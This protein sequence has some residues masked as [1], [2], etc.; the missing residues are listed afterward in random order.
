MM[1]ESVI[2][3]SKSS[4][5]LSD[6]TLAAEQ[7]IRV[8]KEW[9]GSLLA[10]KV[11]NHTNRPVRIKEIVLFSGELPLDPN[12]PFYGE[13]FMMLCQYA[14]TLAAPYLIGAYGTDW[15]FFRLP[16]T[17]Y[18]ENLW[19]VYNLIHLSP[20]GED[21]IMMAFTSCRRF[22]G[23]FRFKDS[24]MEIVMDTEDLTLAP[25][26]SW[27]LEEFYMTG[28]PDANVLYDR[29]AE[30]INRN[31][32]R[33]IYPD[34]PSG[35]CSYYCLRPMTAE[36]L[37]ENARGIAERIPELERIQIDGG[38]EAHNGDWLVPRPSLGADLK[39]I[40]DGIRA[41]GVEAAGYISPFIVST[42]SDLFR[43][44]PDWLVCDEEG[45]PFNEIGR[46]REW[47]MLDGTNPGTQHYFRHIARV[48]HDEWGIR[49]FKLD[50]LAY[51][52]LPGGVRYDKNATRVEAFR[53]GIQAIVEEVGHDSFILG[54]NA[55]FWPI[56]GLIHGN[57]V[58]N[59]IGR[60]WRLVSNNAKELFYR[61]WQH[62]TLWIN[63]PDVIVLESLDLSSRKNGQLVPRPSTLTE[64]EFEFH[65]AFIAASGGMIL[66]GDLIWQLSDKNIGILKKLIADTGAAARFDGSSF[67][68]GRI[69]KEDRQVLCVFNWEDAVHPLTIKLEGN[70]RI[71]D[72]WSDEALG[73]YSGQL[74]IDLEPH[75]GRVLV[76]NPL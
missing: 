45:K 58:T 73:E 28:G 32:P 3:N 60:N 16:K 29:L 14:G 62:D 44:H 21:A 65:K 36:G 61:N 43:E 17:K 1:N 41:E 31:H 22:S 37:Y 7:E 24:Y 48:M 55:P 13:G 57:R 2:K 20:Q 11:T 27:E 15:D 75:Q 10:S 19:T 47:Y 67:T 50:F 4:V 23:E 12:T 59:D 34:I 25:D 72:Y 51:G 5:R 68:I 52:C 64:N 33:K 74:T 18:N 40:C 35:W 46:K 63:D 42:E 66:S 71:T 6:G 76:C 69:N 26:Q 9:N 53:Q 49:Y 70:C 38:Y 56:L 39:T 30:C 8:E 54:C